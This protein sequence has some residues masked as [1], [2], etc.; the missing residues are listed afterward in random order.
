MV[1]FFVFVLGLMAGSFLNAVIYRLEVR[2]GLRRV[3][4]NREKAHLTAFRGRSFCPHCGHQLSWQDLVPL[5]SFMLLRGKC[6]YC[7][8]Q[9][10]WQYPLVE[11]ATAFLFA[12]LFSLSVEKLVSLSYP[13]VLEIAYL[14]AVASLLIVIFVYDLK[15]F[16]IPDKIL[17]PAILISSIW[18]LVFSSAGWIPLYQILNTA[19]SALGA[20]AFFFLIYA[21]SKGKAMG[22]GDV[23]LALFMGLFLGWPN[24]LV[25]LTLAFFAGALVGLLLIAA[26]KKTL[27][28]EVPFGPFLIGGTFAALFWGQPVINW[29]LHLFLP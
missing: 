12:S 27:K 5:L 1:W 28:S 2:E 6:R 20:A 7:G 26:Q 17:Y 19:Y 24:I 10:S 9:I 22:F 13:Q 4:Q 15:H 18:Y 11:L 25:A 8:K 21:I 16:I 14:W 3:S 23:K 29:Y